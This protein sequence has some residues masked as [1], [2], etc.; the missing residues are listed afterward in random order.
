MNTLSTPNNCP[1]P[2][3]ISSW[4]DQQADDEQEVIT[5][6]L[7]ECRKCGQVARAYQSIDEGVSSVQS[8]GEPPGLS[9][10]IQSRCRSLPPVPRTATPFPNLFWKAAAVLALVMAAT[11]LYS[12]RREGPATADGGDDPQVESTEVANAS[13]APAGEPQYA[14]S[15]EMPASLGLRNQIQPSL[16]AAELRLVGGQAPAFRIGTG[17]VVQPIPRSV[18]HVWLIPENKWGDVREYLDEYHPQGNWKKADEQPAF[19]LSIADTAL[20]ALVDKVDKAGAALVSGTPPQPRG[21]VTTAFTGRNVDY[22]MVFITQ[23]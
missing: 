17:R 22:R 18:R 16:D 14:T 7:R 20:Q 13:A 11:A 2:E 8:A 15:I 1:N 23:E 12:S 19:E 5:E 6:H 9:R 21:A 3:K 10:H 4:I